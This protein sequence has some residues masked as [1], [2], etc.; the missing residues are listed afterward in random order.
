MS[1][2]GSKERD[3]QNRVVRLFRDE[4]NYTYLGNWEYRDNNSN[5]EETLL[6]AYLQ[7]QGYDTAQIN[8]A[9]Y[10]LTSTANNFS[11]SLYLT[12]KNVYQLLRY[13]ANVKTDVS[14]NAETVHFINWQQWDKND[15][16]I[17][18]EVTIKRIGIEKKYRTH[19]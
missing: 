10:A 15:F 3:T 16:A 5:V 17:A 13:G 2:V 19:W 11:D 6:T 9:I 8:K 18:E 12:N 7:K 4:L 14:K 1:K